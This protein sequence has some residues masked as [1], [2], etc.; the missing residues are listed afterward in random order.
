MAHERTL[1]TALCYGAGVTAAE[2]AVEP[3][4]GPGS[5]FLIGR[6]AVTGPHFP[7]KL[8]D[9]DIGVMLGAAGGVNADTVRIKAF[10]ELVERASALEAGLPEAE[11]DLIRASLAELRRSSGPLAL[12]PSSLQLFAPWQDLPDY[13][14][15][16]PDDHVHTWCRGVRISTSEPVYVP[17]VAAFLGWTPPED[18]PLFVFPSS[19]GL[20]A[21]TDPDAALRRALLEVIERDASVLAWRIPGYPMA[22]LPL[23]LVS[24][25][26]LQT[27]ALLGLE[28]EVYAVTTRGLPPTVVVVLSGPADAELTCGLAC[29]PLDEALVG[30]A[31]GEALMLQWTMRNCEL[32]AEAS[33][34]E[35]QTLLEHVAAAFHAGPRIANWFRQQAARAP[36]PRA[37]PLPDDPR[38]LARLA[39]RVYGSPVVAIDVTSPRARESGWYVFRVVVPDALWLE[40][41]TCVAHLGGPRLER[42]RKPSP[43]SPR[44]LHRAPHPY[45]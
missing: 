2:V 15:R 12:A 14:E 39:E 40:T 35:P 37:R 36:R 11:P 17:A 1:P 3:A 9:G 13:L 30:K 29:G 41:A 42:F 26:L 4:F 24:E 10:G 33:F 6:T 34:A 20:A 5:P 45:G 21:G 32:P 8:P 18:E 19:S 31:V 43:D 27:C 44:T 23:R 22:R 7:E 25:P 16:A 38:A 28:P